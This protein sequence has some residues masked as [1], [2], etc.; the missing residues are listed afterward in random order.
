MQLRR[1]PSLPSTCAIF[2]G[3]SSFPHFERDPRGPSQIPCSDIA[4]LR[5]RLPAGGRVVQRIIPAY[6]W[7]T[8]LATVYFCLFEINTMATQTPMGVH[9]HMDM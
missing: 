2:P 9:F 4:V 3:L 1:P 8:I 6:L 7:D 5:D